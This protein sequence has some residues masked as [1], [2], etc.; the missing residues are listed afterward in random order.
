M[1]GPAVISLGQVI[2]DLTMRVDAV[3]RPGEDVFADGCRAQ[4]GASYNMMHAVR[5][6]GVEA[7][8]GGVVGRGP[9]ASMIEDALRRDGIAHVGMRLD[10]EDNGFCIALTDAHA[11][12]TF[13]STRGAEAHAPDDAFA[14]IEPDAHDVLYISGYTLVHPT[15]RALLAFLRRTAGH[16]WAAVFD[17]SPMVAQADDLTLSTL[18]G[19][20]PVWT[21]NEREA[22][23]L[24][25]RLGVGARGGADAGADAAAADGETDAAAAYRALADALG[26][27]LIVR[28]GSGGAWVCDGA[29]TPVP[30]FP[31]EPVDTNGAGDCHTGVLCACLARGLPLVDAVRTANA[32]ASIAVTR[33]GPATCPERR[34]VERLLAAGR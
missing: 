30:G 1:S 24:A 23:L 3:P 4:V 29:C 33:R 18:V 31:V 12:R 15:A 8:H 20:R 34:E 7:R 9:W 25:A 13:V 5:R 21:C 2:V 26:A 28:V 10:G 14:G 11:E 22:G 16:R 17:A 27:P 32:A 6:M 19:Y